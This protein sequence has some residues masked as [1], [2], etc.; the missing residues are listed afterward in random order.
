MMRPQFNKTLIGATLLIALTLGLGLNLVRTL[1]IKARAASLSLPAPYTVKLRQTVVSSSGAAFPEAF[2]TIAVRSD[3][4]RAIVMAQSHAIGQ[5]VNRGIEF[6]AGGRLEIGDLWD[7]KTSWPKKRLPPVAQWH[8]ASDQ[9]CLVS[10]AGTP[11]QGGEKLDGFE[12]I[13]GYKAVR[14]SNGRHMM[15]F[16]LDYSCAKL[17]ARY[18]FGT[19]INEH[20]FVALIPGEPDATLFNAP[21]TYKEVSPSEF[22]AVQR[23]RLKQPCDGPHC[24]DAERALDKLYYAQSVTN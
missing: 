5:E 23:D 2:Q 17:Q 21:A 15:W 7:I 13:A 11:M 6:A 12:T 8:R 19:S 18:D 22:Y 9:N 10:L 14:I 1:P 3:G 4:S 24:M 20:T 16:A